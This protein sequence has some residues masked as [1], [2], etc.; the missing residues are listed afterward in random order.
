MIISALLIILIVIAVAS[1]TFCLQELRYSKE[2]LNKF[3]NLFDK[4]KK[5]IKEMEK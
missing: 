2:N 5:E 1:I 3:N 4:I